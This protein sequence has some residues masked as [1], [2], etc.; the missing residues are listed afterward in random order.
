MNPVLMG[1]DL[2][3]WSEVLHET[4]FGEEPGFPQEMAEGFDLMG[5]AEFTHLFLFGSDGSVLWFIDSCGFLDALIM[6]FI[7][8][9]FLGS[10]LLRLSQ[11]NG[12]RPRLCPIE[13][14]SRRRTG[15]GR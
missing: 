8:A 3:L 14:K 4:G 5:V 1:K 13:E 12:E 7:E 15:S 9:E 11:V 10:A 2:K 6:G